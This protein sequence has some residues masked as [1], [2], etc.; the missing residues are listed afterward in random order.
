MDVNN[1]GYISAIDALLIINHLNGIGL[2]GG[3][4]GES[5]VRFYPD[6]NGD[7]RISAIDALLVI[8]HMNSR[9]LSGQGEGE[10]AAPA[11]TSTPVAQRLPRTTSQ[12]TSEQFELSSAGLHGPATPDNYYAA[13]IDGLLGMEDDEEDSEDWLLALASD[14]EAQLGGGL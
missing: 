9:S 2:M 3:G 14:V 4:E 13:Y 7:N 5:G 11:V 6:T 10:S 8:N 1:D 12:P